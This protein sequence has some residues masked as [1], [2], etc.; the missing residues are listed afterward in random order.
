[1]T[2]QAQD[3]LNPNKEP[4]KAQLASA[5]VAAAH[6]IPN[7]CL[8]SLAY[9]NFQVLPALANAYTTWSQA[10]KAVKKG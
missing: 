8:P 3:K 5:A 10:E 1:M 2:V 4:Q 9:L 7:W 6:D